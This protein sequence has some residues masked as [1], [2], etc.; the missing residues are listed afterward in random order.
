MEDTAASYHRVAS[1]YDLSSDETLKFLVGFLSRIPRENRNSVINP[2]FIGG[3]ANGVV[4][5]RWAKYG[6]LPRPGDFT[7]LCNILLRTF[8]D[9]SDI[10]YSGHSN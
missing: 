4:F 2:I 1:T 10:P 8:A 6:A 3:F 7:T 5:A 9:L